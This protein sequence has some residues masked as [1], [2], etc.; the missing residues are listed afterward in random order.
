[1][2]GKVL[3]DQE[4]CGKLTVKDGWLLCPVC[5]KGKVLKVRADTEVKNL[6]VRCKLCRQK[7]LVN[8]KSLSQSRSASA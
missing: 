3:R 7:S 5:R 1:M 2:E 6:E 8:I 4:S